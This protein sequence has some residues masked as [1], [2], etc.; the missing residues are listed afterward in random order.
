MSYNP[1][2]DE[3]LDEFCCYFR[4]Y[5]REALRTSDEDFK[6]SVDREIL[7]DLEVE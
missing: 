5:F 6:E 7:K 4:T 2:L 3:I 1:L